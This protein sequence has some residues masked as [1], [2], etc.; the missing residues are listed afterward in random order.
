[1][2]ERQD[3]VIFGT[4]GHARVLHDIALDCSVFTVLGFVAPTAD[5]ECLGLPALSDDRLAAA[6]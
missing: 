2:L 5:A 1:M 6:A 4:G 3:I